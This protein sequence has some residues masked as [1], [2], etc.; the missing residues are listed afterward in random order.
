MYSSVR[1]SPARLAMPLKCF[2][3]SRQVL[4]WRMV[5]FCRRTM[6][7]TYKPIIDDDMERRRR[8]RRDE[9]M[10]MCYYDDAVR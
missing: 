8:G 2:A 9:M 3:E 5:S 10:M 4:Q 1:C 7:R 6:R